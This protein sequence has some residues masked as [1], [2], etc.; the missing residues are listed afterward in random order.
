[1]A[2]NQENTAQNQ[3]NAAQKEKSVI[4]E[5]VGKALGHLEK[6]RVCTSSV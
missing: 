5:D 6:I 1:M 2:Q 3:E 4:P